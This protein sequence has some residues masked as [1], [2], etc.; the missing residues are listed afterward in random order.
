MRINIAS[1]NPNKIAAVKE[2][3]KDYPLLASAK[4]VARKPKSEVADQPKSLEETVNGAIN[5]AKNDFVDCDYSIGLESG[6]MKVPKTKTGYM[7]VCACAIYD[8][9]QFHLGLSSAFEYPIKV[10][11]AVLKKGLDI[12]QAFFKTGL[13]KNPKVGSA[14]GVIGFL[15]KGRLPRK[16]YNKQ[17]LTMALIHLENKE[18]YQ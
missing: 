18:L 13:T 16:D 14:E 12:N 5:R 9:K 11:K 7:D 2:I 17:A 6:L 10:T 3:I 8:G 4:I 15:T 1:Q